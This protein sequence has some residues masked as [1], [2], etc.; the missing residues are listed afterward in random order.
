MDSGALALSLVCTEGMAVLLSQPA[1]HAALSRV[2]KGVYVGARFGTCFACP[3]RC[4]WRYLT[5]GETR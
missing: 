1:A 2:W 5:R 3:R 4:A